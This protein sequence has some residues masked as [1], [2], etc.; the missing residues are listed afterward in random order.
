MP[1]SVSPSRTM[2]APMS[3]AARISRA[4]RVVA[5]GAIE[6][7]CRS[8]PK[9]SLTNLYLKVMV[10]LLPTQI[11]WREPE[12]SDHRRVD[13]SSVATRARKTSSQLRGT[14]PAGCW[15]LHG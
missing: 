7:T 1:T 11:G 15:H 3:F 9:H 10:E 12:S 8:P 14:A 4:E 6:K 13:N 5:W 2:R